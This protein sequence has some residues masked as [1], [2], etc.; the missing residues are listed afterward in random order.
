MKTR[1]LLVGITVGILGF[2]SNLSAQQVTGTGSLVAKGAVTDPVGQEDMDYVTVGSTMPYEVTGFDWGTL[3][4]VVTPLFNWSVTGTGTSNLYKADGSTSLAA[5]AD[6]AGFYPD[7][8]ISIKWGTAGTYT[9]NVAERGK[10]TSTASCPDATPETLPITVLAWPKVDWGTITD[11]TACGVASVS[12]PLTVKGSKSITVS[13]DV[14]YTALAT[15]STEQKLTATPATQTYTNTG[16]D[17][18]VTSPT[19]DYTVVNGTGKYRIVITNI[20]DKIT[21]KSFGALGATDASRNAI[22][23]DLPLAGVTFYSLPTPV[24]SPIQHIKNL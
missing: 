11:P 5:D 13:Y 21:E 16:Y 2:F 10:F 18:A 23:A 7:K 24:T 9:I 14:Y 4:G 12:L 1:I 6:F 3:S 15:G 20:Q 19:L 17:V 22:A 8:S